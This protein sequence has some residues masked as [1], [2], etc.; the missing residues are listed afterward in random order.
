MSNH[1]R[2][3]HLRTVEAYMRPFSCLV[4]LVLS[5]T[6]VA[7]AQSTRPHRWAQL[8]ATGSEAI[9][10]DTATLQRT[11]GLRR[12][13]LRWDL[14]RSGPVFWRSTSL[15]TGRSTARV[16]SR[17][18][19]PSRPTTFRLL[20]RLGCQTLLGRQTRSAPRTQCGTQCRLAALSTSLLKLFVGGVKPAPNKRV[21]LAGGDRP[22]G[23]GVFVP[24]REG[25]FVQYS[26]AG[27]RVARSLSASR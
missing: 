18:C 20:Q 24:W 25:T 5:T 12:V 21:K 23:S 17:A 19:W 10:L 16:G 14:D 27:G 6:R 15:S 3:R 9:D 4:L 2:R 11:D 26:G 7:A 13:W 8:I 22:K 1:V